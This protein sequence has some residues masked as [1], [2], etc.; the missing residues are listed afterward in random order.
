MLL[1]HLDA[2]SILELGKAHPPTLNVLQAASLLWNK[3]IQKTCPYDTRRPFGDRPDTP[4]L[5]KK[6]KAKKAKLAPLIH[7][8][9]KMEEPQ[10]FL[11]SLLDL[12]CTRFPVEE[13]RRFTVKDAGGKIVHLSESVE[14]TCNQQAVSYSVSPLGFLVLEEV[15]G[16]L[17]SAVQSVSKVG[18]GDLGGLLLPSLGSRMPRQQE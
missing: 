3:L 1:T 5:E 7:L 18:L 11:V 14:V 12:I 2:N 6:L 13:S 4:W 15:D 17:G 10:D 8:L 16:A 9:A